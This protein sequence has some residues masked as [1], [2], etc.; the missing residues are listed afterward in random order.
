[1]LQ[2][3][4]YFNK[5]LNEAIPGLTDMIGFKIFYQFPPWELCVYGVLL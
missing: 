3:Q 1:M 2:L 5:Q 4:F